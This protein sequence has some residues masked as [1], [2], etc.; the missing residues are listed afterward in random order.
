M[1]CMA[2]KSKLLLFVGFT[3]FIFRLADAQCSCNRVDSIR[4]KCVVS[5]TGRNITSNCIAGSFDHLDIE[6]SGTATLT[7]DINPVKSITIFPTSSDSNATLQLENFK[8]NTSSIDISINLNTAQMTKP[9]FLSG[10]TGVK[11]TSLTVSIKQTISTIDQYKMFD[12]T[13][14]IDITQYQI[15]I[16]ADSTTSIGVIDH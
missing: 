12:T 11:N 8:T 13:T 4:V 9:L 14:S 2:I 5:T 15:L 7:L 10:I 1:Q 3:V 16:N 6:Y